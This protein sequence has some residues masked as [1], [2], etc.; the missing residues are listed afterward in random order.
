MAIGALAALIAA[1]AAIAL[2]MRISRPLAPQPFHF[3][4]VVAVTPTVEINAAE[5]ARLE[6]VLRELGQT[7]SDAGAARR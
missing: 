1:A 3:P 7:P 5:R 6:Q 2:V 4:A